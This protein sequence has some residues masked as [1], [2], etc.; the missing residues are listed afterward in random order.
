[1]NV[2]L[3]VRSRKK[4]KVMGRQSQEGNVFIMTWSTE[5]GNQY[6]NSAIQSCA[7]NAII[8]VQDST[9]EFY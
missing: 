1:M 2:I 3:H 9:Q 8:R 7:E 6:S 4:V 5:N